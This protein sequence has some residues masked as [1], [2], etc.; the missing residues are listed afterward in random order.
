MNP[1]SVVLT[2]LS[3]GPK[4]AKK[5]LYETEKMG[6]STGDT[7]M[8]LGS[9]VDSGKAIRRK[10]GCYCITAVWTLAWALTGLQ[11]SLSKLTDGVVNELRRDTDHTKGDA[12]GC[13]PVEANEDGQTKKSCCEACSGNCSG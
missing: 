4:S 7:Y 6:V 2:V 3:S 10:D 13:M 8:A 5:V 11:F 9:C 1:E 12:R